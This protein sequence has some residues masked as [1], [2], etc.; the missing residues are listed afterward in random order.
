MLASARYDRIAITVLWSRPQSENVKMDSNVVYRFHQ[1]GNREVGIYLGPTLLCYFFSIFLR[2]IKSPFRQLLKQVNSL[3]QLEKLSITSLV[4]LWSL[5]TKCGKMRIISKYIYLWPN[6][7]IL[8]NLWCSFQL[9]QWI[10]S[11]QKFDCLKGEEY[12]QSVNSFV[13]G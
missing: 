3:W 7:T 12:I 2:L 13:F 1:R 5:V 4:K 11:I 8:L 9:P 10:F 6:S